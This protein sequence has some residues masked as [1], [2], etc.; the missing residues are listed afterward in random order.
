MLLL[1]V[2]LCLAGLAFL[3]LLGIGVG[4]LSQY[5]SAIH[6]QCCEHTIISVSVL[7]PPRTANAGLKWTIIRIVFVLVVDGVDLEVR[8]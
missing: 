7:M 5:D 2:T 1:R 6:R 3:V 4:V 8:A